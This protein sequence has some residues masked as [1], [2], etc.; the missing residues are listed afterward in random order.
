MVGGGGV[1]GITFTLTEVFVVPRGKE[2]TTK[3]NAYVIVTGDIPE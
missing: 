1:F 3:A 2:Y